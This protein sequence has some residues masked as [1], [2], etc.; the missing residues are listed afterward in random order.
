MK[1]DSLPRD[2][3]KTRYNRIC[4]LTGRCTNSCVIDTIASQVEQGP[5]TESWASLGTNSEISRTVVSYQELGE[6]TGN[7][8]DY[9]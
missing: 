1:L 7:E 8:T 9:L 4:M 5:S 3:S 6:Q 2:S